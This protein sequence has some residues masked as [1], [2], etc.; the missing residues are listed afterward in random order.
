MWI[1]SA[2]IWTVLPHYKSEFRGLPNEEAARNALTPQ[3]LPPG[4]YNIPHVSSP[5]NFEKADVRKK[6]E[7]GPA[8][9]I[10]VVLSSVPAMGQRMVLSFVY[11]LVIGVVVAYVASRTLAPEA[12]YLTVFRLTGTVAW[13]AYGTGVIPDAVRFGRP[14]SAVAK[15]LI[16]ALAY[17]LLTAGVFGWLWPR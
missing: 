10:T 8:C 15:H 17:G 11:Y 16:D 7:E 6:F 13:L 9:F 5:Q 1:V 4:Q 14:W 3:N 2:L 12:E